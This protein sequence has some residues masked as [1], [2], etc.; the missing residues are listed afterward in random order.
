MNQ[1]SEIDKNFSNNTKSSDDLRYYDIMDGVFAISGFA[2]LDIDKVFCRFPQSKLSRLSSLLQEHSWHTSGGMVRFKTDS[3]AIAIKAEL[4]N[5][6][7]MSHMT[8]AGSGGFDLYLGTGSEKNHFKTAMPSI[9]GSEINS[10]LAEGLGK[11]VR[12]WTINFPL[13]GGV[14][15]VTIG[16]NDGCVIEMP[17]PFTIKKPIVFYGSSVTQGGCASRP[18][19]DYT[20]HICRWLDANCLNFGFSGNAKGEKEVADILSTLEMS[21]FVM[22]YDYNTPNIEHL[23]RTHSPFFQVMR[24][25]QPNIPIVFVSAPVVNNQCLEYIQRKDVIEKTFHEALELGDKNVYFVD[26]GTLFGEHDRDACTVDGCHPNDLGFMQM[27]K[28]LYPVIKKALA[29]SLN[30]N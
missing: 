4:G 29:G 14:K 6:A 11:E 22:D 12:E 1:T 10:I 24:K 2:W 27:A 21:A 9:N 25:A 30:E 19:N 7:D 26:G 15:K 28:T 13:Y 23:E 16:V 18:G 17:S 5:F 8:R 20:H 3:Q